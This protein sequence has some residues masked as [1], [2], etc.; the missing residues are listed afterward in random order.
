MAVFWLAPLAWCHRGLR[1][2]SLFFTLLAAAGLGW[3]LGLPGFVDVFRMWP[4]TLFS[5]NRWVFATSSSV[6]VLAAIGLESLR[7]GPPRFQRRF[8]VPMLLTAVFG[9]WCLF[10][11]FELPEPLHSQIE[12]AIRRGGS[13][14]LSLDRLRAAQ[15]TFSRCYAVGALLSLAAEA[16]WLTTFWSTRRL[17]WCRLAIIVLLPVQLFLFAWQERRQADRVLYF[18]RVAALEKLTALPPGRIWGIDC[19]PP[20]LSQFHGL[21]DIRGYDAVDPSSFVKLFNLACAL[22][23]HRPRPMR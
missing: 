11:C 23:V 8:V 22:P 21:D 3:T 16:G 6:L 14:G 13:V 1:R 20:N 15:R 10:R 19:L 7:N 17:V 18:P 2:Q 4:L 12:T 9:L 5:F